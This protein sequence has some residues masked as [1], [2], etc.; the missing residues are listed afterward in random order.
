MSTTINQD[1]GEA[2]VIQ[3]YLSLNL[4]SELKL[5]TKD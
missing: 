3:H 2:K 1:G 4:F 5:H